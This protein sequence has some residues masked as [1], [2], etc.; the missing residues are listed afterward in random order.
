MPSKLVIFLINIVH[1][2]QVMNSIEFHK[3][4]FI[5]NYFLIQTFNFIISLVIY[6][7]KSGGD[8]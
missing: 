1:Y 6:R 3:T 7:S 4:I 5:I 8:K 2:L